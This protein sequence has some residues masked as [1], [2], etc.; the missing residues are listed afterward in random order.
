MT[1]P[2]KIL[3]ILIALLPLPAMAE[4]VRGNIV[5]TIDDANAALSLHALFSYRDDKPI[6]AIEGKLDIKSAGSQI[7]EQ[8]HTLDGD[9]LLQQWFYD[10]ALNF[11]FLV[12][13]PDG[14]MQLAIQT[15]QVKDTQRYTGT[16]DFTISARDPDDDD[17]GRDGNVTCTTD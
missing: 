6:F 11:R 4:D 16:Y 15:N 5:C 12:P 13:T 17:V 8:S 1:S 2:R 3:A 7:A 9:T 10:S 14:T